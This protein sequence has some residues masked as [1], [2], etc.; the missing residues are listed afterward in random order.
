M[1]AQRLAVTAAVRPGAAGDGLDKGP[2]GK[3]EH[4]QAADVL[5]GLEGNALG[6]E[7]AREQSQRGD[8]HQRGGGADRGGQ[9]AVGGGQVAVVIWVR[10][11]HSLMKTAMK[12]VP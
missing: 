1:A 4:A 10:S 6:D 8:G 5:H 11:P 3:G 9:G 2:D 12:A 7:P